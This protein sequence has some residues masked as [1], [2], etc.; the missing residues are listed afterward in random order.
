MEKAVA[1]FHGRSRRARFRA[2]LSLRKEWRRVVTTA[3][4]L[5]YLRALPRILKK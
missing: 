3:P 1:I 4:L 2:A 5:N